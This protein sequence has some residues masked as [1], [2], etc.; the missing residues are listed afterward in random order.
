MLRGQREIKARKSATYHAQ[1]QQD[2]KGNNVGHDLSA[3]VLGVLDKDLV[4]A[5]RDIEFI[6]FHTTAEV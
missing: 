2:Q 3:S 5:G 6:S 1:D 4:I